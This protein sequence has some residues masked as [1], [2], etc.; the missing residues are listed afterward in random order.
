[1]E[2]ADL[3][4]SQLLGACSAPCVEPPQALS[5]FVLALSTTCTPP[6][7]LKVRKTGRPLPGPW[8]TRRR[9]TPAERFLGATLTF[10]PPTDT[11]STVN[12]I[13]II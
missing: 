7:R 4:P 1:M 13:R 8:L 11:Y 6:P 5:T 2:T 9:G 10:P 3:A 12:G